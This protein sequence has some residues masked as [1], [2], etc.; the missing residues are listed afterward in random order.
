MTMQDQ[1]VLTSL[2]SPGFSFQNKGI[3]IC[4]L[5]HASTGTGQ[6]LILQQEVRDS[7]LSQWGVQDNNKPPRKVFFIK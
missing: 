6:A 3:D 2:D 5:V 1:L 4:S 7:R